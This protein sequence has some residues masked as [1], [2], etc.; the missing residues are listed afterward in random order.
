MSQAQK[1]E[2]PALEAHISIAHSPEPDK[3][4][5]GA[6]PPVGGPQS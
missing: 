4:K 5:P 3:W 6:C 2:V 1:K